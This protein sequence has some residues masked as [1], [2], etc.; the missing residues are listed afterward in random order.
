MS[1]F[2]G[3]PVIVLGMGRSGTSYLSSFLAANGVSLGGDLLEGSIINPRGFYE[4]KEILAFHQRILRRLNATADWD[5]QL[6]DLLPEPQLTPEEKEHAVRIL[7]RLAKP[8]PWGWKEPRTVRFI[9]FW[10]SLLP[11]AK[12][13]VPLRHPLEIF[14]SYLKQ[15]ATTADLIDVKRTFRAYTQ[16]HLRIL[17]I[18]RER[19]TRSLV[20]N[21]QEA[22]ADPAALW[23]KL[24]HFLE[25]EGAPGRFAVPVFS[26]SEFT[27]L[28]ITRELSAIFKTLLPDAAAAFDSLNDRSAFRAIPDPCPAE[29][30]PVLLHLSASIRAAG[31]RIANETWLPVLID[32]CAPCESEG[33]FSLQGRILARAS[34][35]VEELS[36]WIAELEKARDF[37]DRQAAAIKDQAA[38]IAQLEEARDWNAQ[39][40]VNWQAEAQRLAGL[41]SAAN[42]T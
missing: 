7:G 32:L 35:R 11:E 38:W 3:N 31:A 42:K 28:A 2:P 30:Q 25:I 33:Y 10:L 26:P 34:A 36:G 15:V 8:G 12:V 1:T 37:W 29:L 21:A 9:R 18:V 6:S 13:V 27:R 17:E 19:P 23:V 5:N 39:Q 16:Y 24:K 14:Y 22:F 41:L 20:L 40:A 4:D